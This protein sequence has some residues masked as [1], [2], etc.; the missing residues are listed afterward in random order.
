LQVIVPSSISFG[1][2]STLLQGGD[3]ELCSLV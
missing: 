1:K 3:P 2:G